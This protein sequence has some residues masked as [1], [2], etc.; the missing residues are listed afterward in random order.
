MFAHF[1]AACTLAL[2]HTST[3]A[4]LHPCIHACK[5]AGMLARACV[6]AYANAG[7]YAHAHTDNALERTSHPYP[8]PHAPTHTCAPFTARRVPGMQPWRMSRRPWL[9]INSPQ[10]RMPTRCRLCFLAHIRA[11]RTPTSAY[12]SLALVAGQGLES[13]RSPASV[14][15]GGLY[16]RL[17]L[18]RSTHEVASGRQCGAAIVPNFGPNVRPSGLGVRPG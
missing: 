8:V 4:H 13:A 7:V 5:Q 9:A 18:S 6:H 10:H 1:Q 15:S 11:F 16:R 3:L 17:P 12:A 14:A 2:P